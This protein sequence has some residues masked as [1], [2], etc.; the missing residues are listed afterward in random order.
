MK[1]AWLVLCLMAFGCSKSATDVR[2]V[3]KEESAPKI[4][5]KK[6]KDEQPPKKKDDEPKKVAE[7]KEPEKKPEPPKKSEFELEEDRLGKERNE[8]AAEFRLLPSTEQRLMLQM[9]ELMRK[10]DFKQLSK[11]WDFQLALLLL[12]EHQ[13]HFNLALLKEYYYYR[14]DI[15]GNGDTLVMLLELKEKDVRR[16][17][18]LLGQFELA[19]IAGVTFSVRQAKKDGIG[20]LTDPQRKLLRPFKDFIDNLPN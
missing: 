5:P 17:K 9:D 6:P 3:V 1:N 11:G 7:K 4:E 19:E 18:S 15:G 20:S 2:E 14:A 8:L 10:K 16:F 12:R 13:K